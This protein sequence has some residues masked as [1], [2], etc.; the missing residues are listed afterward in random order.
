MKKFKSEMDI[1]I[2]RT[3]W[4]RGDPTRYAI[5]FTL[6]D[7]RKNLSPLFKAVEI[8]TPINLRHLVH[9]GYDIKTGELRVRANRLDL[10]GLLRCPIFC[11]T[12]TL[13]V[14]SIVSFSQT[15]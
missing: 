7:F 1:G 10:A 14:V 3:A 9:I 5:G 4:D 13:A 8:S 6:P 15:S 12:A 11:V 2:E